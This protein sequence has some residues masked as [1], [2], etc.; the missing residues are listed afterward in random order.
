MI[1]ID[2]SKQQTLH[3]DPR[4]FQQV[5]FNANLDRAGNTRIFFIL[6]EAK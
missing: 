1:A 5:N 4:A 3:A 6:K 2:I